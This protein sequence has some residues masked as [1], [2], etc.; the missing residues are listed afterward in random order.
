MK[1]LRYTDILKK[2]KKVRLVMKFV[3][4]R[5]VF[6]L[7]IACVFLL[8]CIANV[9]YYSC[10]AEAKKQESN[11]IDLS[12][13]SK[14]HQQS[15]KGNGSDGLQPENPPVSKTTKK[16]GLQ[17][18]NPPVSKT[19]KGETSTHVSKIGP[20][21]VITTTSTD[22]HTKTVGN[23]EITTTT[24]LTTNTYVRSK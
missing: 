4:P 17:P 24:V 12:K 23:I 5:S 21:T 8:A 10:D 2:Q 9:I 7:L 19:T 1:L 22:T 3:S 11:I 20:V 18:E 14:E 15:K 16:D 13:I 6:T